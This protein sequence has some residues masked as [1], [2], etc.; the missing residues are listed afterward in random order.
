[1][2]SDR[3][4]VSSYNHNL[5]LTNTTGATLYHV[6]DVCCPSDFSDSHLVFYFHAGVHTVNSKGEL[7]YMSKDYNIKKL[8][9]DMKTT[10]TFIQETD[11]TWDPY[12]V[13]C[14]GFTGDLLVGM[15]SKVARCNQKGILVQTIQHDNTGLE[16]FL[17]P[18]F[19]T[20]NNNGDIVV[21][22][23][24]MSSASGSVV[25][26]DCEGRHRFSYPEH[27]P[28]SGLWSHGI[29]TDE[30]SNI[31]ICDRVF[32]HILDSSGQFLS[33]LKLK[34]G[35]Y[36]SC[37]CYDVNSRRVWIE[38]LFPRQLLVCSHYERQE[39]IIGRYLRLSF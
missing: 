8:S 23:C 1:M 24:S 39:V 6:Q 12:C 18:H 13:W 21:S 31:L 2:T 19:I 17:E 33:H 26:T 10:T 36:P 14:S 22:D 11:S 20:E 37:L 29:C 38:S 35:L 27:P 7:I 28:G 15:Y 9:N 5:I 25:V 3:A 16:M 34:E 30:L 4:W 32:I